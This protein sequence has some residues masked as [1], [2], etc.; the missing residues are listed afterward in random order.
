MNERCSLSNLE[1]N[2]AT[3][4]SSLVIRNSAARPITGSNGWT[5]MTSVLKSLHWLPVVIQFQILTLTYRALHDLSPACLSELLHPYSSGRSLWSNTLNLLSVPRNHL[6]AQSDQAFQAVEPKLW[7]ALPLKSGSLI[8]C[9]GDE[10]RDLMQVN[11]KHT[12]HF[13]LNQS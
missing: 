8:R 5:H 3:H 4:L 9:L 13:S 10:W 11:I 6:K 1:E 2:T 7:K 12:G